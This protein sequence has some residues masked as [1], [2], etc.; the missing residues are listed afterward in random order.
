MLSTSTARIWLVDEPRLR[1]RARAWAGAK[2]HSSIA[3]S[4]RFPRVSP[5]QR[6]S[7]QKRDT[8]L[9]RTLVNFNG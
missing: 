3:R 8:S 5:A 9:V 1:R 4:M 6:A 7:Q 2:T